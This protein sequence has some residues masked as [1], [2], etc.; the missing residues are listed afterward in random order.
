LNQP[1]SKSSLSKAQ[2]RLVELLQI[3]NFGRIE[4]LRVHRGEPIFT[5]P[6]RVIQTLKMG[7]RNGPREEVNL[8]DFW[9]KQP[10]VDLLQTMRDI[11]DGELMAIAI[12]HGLPHLVERQLNQLGEDRA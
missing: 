12:A 5:P 2:A 1:I 9:L 4:A 7:G 10:I 11:G 3:V 8:E 6:P